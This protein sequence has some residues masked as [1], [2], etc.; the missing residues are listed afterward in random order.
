MTARK[1]P[2]EHAEEPEEA[3]PPAPCVTLATEAYHTFQVSVL[4]LPDTVPTGTVYTR[5]EADQVL[6]LAAKYDVH[7][8]EVT[9]EES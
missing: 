6:T 9:T 5:E 1:K 2:A 8:R 3:A 4:G 7:L